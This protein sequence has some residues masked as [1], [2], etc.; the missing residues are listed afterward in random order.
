MGDY[1]FWKSWSKCF[2]IFGTFTSWKKLLEN[3][4]LNLNIFLFG[5]Q[6]K[7]ER[8]DSIKNKG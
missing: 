8:D 2:D 6:G 7:Y 1:L 5:T 4:I 3:L